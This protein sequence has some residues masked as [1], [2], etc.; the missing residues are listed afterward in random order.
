MAARIY[1]REAMDRQQLSDE[2]AAAAFWTGVRRSSAKALLSH[3]EDIERG[4]T[5]DYGCR[6]DFEVA[7]ARHEAIKARPQ[8]TAEDWEARRP[9]RG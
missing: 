6:E 3:H 7:L 8:W 1:L 5:V 9:T 4:A 2:N